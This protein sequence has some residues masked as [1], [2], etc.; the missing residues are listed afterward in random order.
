MLELMY[1]TGVRI[2]E[3][4]TLGLRDLDMQRDSSGSAAK[5]RRSGSSLRPGSPRGPPGVSDEARQ[6]LVRARAASRKGP[7]SWAAGSPTQP[8]GRLA[9]RARS[10]GGGLQKRVTPHTLRHTFATHLLQG[11]ADIAAVQE[12][13]GHADISTTQIYTHWSA[14]I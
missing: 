3:V 2:S 5:G 12:M 10:V 13:L 7:Y 11:G 8:Q 14:A 1:A 4:V 9:D 6:R